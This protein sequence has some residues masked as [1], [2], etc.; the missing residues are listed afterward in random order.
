MEES[1]ALVARTPA[2]RRGQP[3]DIANAVAFLCRDES[4]FINGATLPGRRGFDL[5]YLRTSMEEVHFITS[6]LS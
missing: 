6:H 5:W 2:R 1:D 3:A 4:E